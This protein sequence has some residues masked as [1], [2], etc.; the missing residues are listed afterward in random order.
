M[1]SPPFVRVPH[2]SYELHVGS[3]AM[4]PKKSDDV[5]SIYLN[6]SMDIPSDHLRGQLRMKG[7][8]LD[9]VTGD[10]CTVALGYG[11]DLVNVYKGTIDTIDIRF[12]KISLVALSSMVKLCALRIDKLYKNVNAGEIVK[13]LAAL[14][15]VTTDTISDGVQFPYY[16]IDSNKNVYEHI[17]ELGRCSGFDAYTNSS[18]MLVFKQYEATE[19][20]I[21]EFGKNILAISKTLQKDMITSVKV[22]GESPGPDK[23]HWLVKE[24]LYAEEGNAS[25]GNQ[26][27][28]RHTIA[29]DKDTVASI[30]K[31]SLSR[32]RSSVSIVI[33]TLGAPKI[34]LGDTVRVQ[35]ALEES[36]NGIYQVRSIEHFLSKS[37]GFSSILHCRGRGANNS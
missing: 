30:A 21:M 3:V 25:E 28:L 27:V 35:K 37:S 10:R 19:P 32:I 29:K 17:M 24:P 20:H 9:F 36:L 2:P 12:S 4:D 23:S 7:P 11:E 15:G 33:E 13:N 18:D 8:N 5:Q 6:L 31:A 26:L 34:A 16:T 1:S 14:A 22:Y